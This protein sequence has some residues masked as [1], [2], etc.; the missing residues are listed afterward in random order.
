MKIV[1]QNLLVPLAALLLAFACESPNRRD[2]NSF[3]NEFL[4]SCSAFA[5]KCSAEKAKALFVFGDSYADTGNRDATNRTLNHGWRRPYGFDWPGYPTGRYSSGKIQTDRWAEI[6]G[7]PTPIPYQMLK[8]HDCE[9][10]P[11]KIVHGVN[12][13]FGSS[14][15]FESEGITIPDQV[16]Q[17][18][19]LMNKTGAFGARDLARSILLLSYGGGDYLPN[20]HR[21][22][23]T[24]LV[25]LVSAVVNG[26]VKFVKE[27][28]D[29]GFRNFVVTDVVAMGCLPLTL[30][31]SCELEKCVQLHSRLLNES[32]HQLRSDLKG[33]SIIIPD[34]PSVFVHIF[35]NAASY[36]FEDW[37]HPCCARNHGVYGC[38]YVDKKGGPYFE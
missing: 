27:L 30:S 17:F 11:N 9:E 33:S 21:N 4:F 3:E 15:L 14:G 19:N 28:Y 10:I 24:V 16:K 18:K 36:G 20:I 34:L 22:N 13:A 2:L 37:F 31:R 25:S 1:K 29:Y 6:L 12:F 23:V 7:L 5:G 8:T 32:L 35:S 38:A 26:V